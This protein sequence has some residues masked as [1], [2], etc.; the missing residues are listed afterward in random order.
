MST[1]MTPHGIHLPEGKRGQAAAL[2]LTLFGIAV[3]WFVVG[4]P[5]VAY[6]DERLEL[7]ER[8]VNLRDRMIVLAQSL[9]QLRRAAADAMPGEQSVGALEGGTDAV[10]AAN[11][12]QALDE[13]AKAEDIR[14][15]SAEMLPGEAAGKWQ[16]ITV[17]ATLSAPWRNLVALLQAIAVADTTMV[18][19][20]LQLRPPPR[21][22]TDPDRPVD[23]TFSVTAWRA[24]E[25]DA[26]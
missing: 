5:V 20:D 19:D 7:L 2:A 24:K 26:Q 4:A 22:V 9:P 16:A 1:S 12:Q 3:L 10:A 14:I 17:R 21:D 8:Q 25:A 13:L 23:A 6:Y 11:L 15:G 18:V